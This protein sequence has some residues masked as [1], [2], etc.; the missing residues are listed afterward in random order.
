[1]N[2]YNYIIKG[3]ISLLSFFIF[4]FTFVFITLWAEKHADIFIMVLSI[5]AVSLI[6]VLFASLSL[7]VGDIITDYFCR[8]KK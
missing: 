2:K 4:S 5:I 1:M 7:W 6:V 8:F 3:F